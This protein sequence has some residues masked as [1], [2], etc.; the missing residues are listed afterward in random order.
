MNEAAARDDDY[1]YYT[2]LPV[3]EILKR[4]RLHYGQSL[5]D[6]ETVLRIRASQLEAIEKGE[7]DKLPGRVYAIGFVRSY[8]EYLGL[9]GDKMVRLFKSQSL[10][11]RDRPE[12]HFPVPA[13]E[14]KI[15][16]PRVLLASAALIILVG[17]VWA[18]LSGGGAD[19][20]DINRIPEVPAEL[21]IETADQSAGAGLETDG[22]A[23][24]SV[25]A[26][27]DVEAGHRVTLEVSERSWVEIRDRSGNAVLSRTLEPGNTYF[28][29]AG[30]DDL[31]L[32]TGNAGGLVISVDGLKLPSFGGRGDIRRDIPL[33]AEEL[34]AMFE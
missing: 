16:G 32:T 9:D 33:K 10:G 3:G 22:P 24:D 26:E 17:I 19:G 7:P 18:M 11:D 6:V 28:V 27:A 34:K 4:A 29:P 2:D 15:P 25:P 1:D 14:S 31:V 8:S 23:S 12:L 5:S 21:K 30:R 13:S 20:E